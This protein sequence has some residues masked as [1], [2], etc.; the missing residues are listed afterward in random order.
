MQAHGIKHVLNPNAYRG[1]FG[2]D[3][4]A[5]ARDVQDVI[6]T[7]TSG[8]VAGFISESIQGVGGTTPLAD[9]YLPAVYDVRSLQTW[10]L[11]CHWSSSE[12]LA[13]GPGVRDCHAQLMRLVAEQRIAGRS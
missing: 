13:Q 5:Y 4:L 2:N 8:R 7:T 3:G 12:E 6:E 11:V 10:A 1:A 9:G